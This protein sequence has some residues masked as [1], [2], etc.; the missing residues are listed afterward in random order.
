M[1]LC[2]MG[3]SGASLFR[4]RVGRVSRPVRDGSGEPSYKKAKP[5]RSTRPCEGANS[6]PFERDRIAMNHQTL[7]FLAVLLAGVAVLALVRPVQAQPARL[8]TEAELKQF[9]DIHPK[10]LVAMMSGEAPVGEK[11]KK[12]IALMAKYYVYFMTLEEWQKDGKA[13]MDRRREF[14]QNL[15]SYCLRDKEKAK[16]KDFR[17]ALAKEMIKCFQKV[18][19]RNA[20][21]QP[22]QKMA[23]CVN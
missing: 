15:E 14:T 1:V 21:G 17:S 11:E 9:K 4:F 5:G 20:F 8:V 6:H 2:T 7:R 18:F 13:L 22:E 19:A 3:A 23:S 16:N 10:D 12:D